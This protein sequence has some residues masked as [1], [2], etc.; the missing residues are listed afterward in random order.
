MKIN[1]CLP[2]IKNSKEKVLQEILQNIGSFDFFEVWVDYVENIDEKFI[3]NLIEKIGEKLI[4]VFRRQNIEELKMNKEKR[5]KI[6]S[7]LKNSQ[8]FLDLDIFGQKDE[9]DYIKNNKEEVKTIVSYH[10]H[11][12]T[13]NDSKLEEIIDTMKIY[14]PE[15]FKIATKCNSSKDALRLLRL[16]LAMKE[17]DV[18]AIVLGMGKLGVITRIFGTIWGN[19]MIF[20]PLHVTESSAPGQLTKEQLETIFKVLEG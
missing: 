3:Q 18:K 17:K 1:Y 4:I 2:I 5:L 10:N 13:P 6:I 19:E 16:L 14:D 7:L 8:A 11:Q 15:I 20:T 12:E 9:L